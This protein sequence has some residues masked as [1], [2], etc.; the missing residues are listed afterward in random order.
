MSSSLKMGKLIFM[1]PLG[2]L[3]HLPW[4]GHWEPSDLSDCNDTAEAVNKELLLLS[5]PWSGEGEG[6]WGSSFV[7]IHNPCLVMAC[8]ERANGQSQCLIYFSQGDSS[9]WENLNGWGVV[10]WECRCP[11]PLAPIWHLV[12]AW[13]ITH[14]PSHMGKGSVAMCADLPTHVPGTVSINAVSLTSPKLRPSPRDC[15]P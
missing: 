13:A 6:D 7:I 12:M 14:W 4:W 5:N 2:F 3:R 11:G 9:P 8:G 10:G 15:L 1:W